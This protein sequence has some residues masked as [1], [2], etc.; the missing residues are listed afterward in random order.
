MFIESVLYAL[1]FFFDFGIIVICQPNLVVKLYRFFSPHEG[2]KEM[3]CSLLQEGILLFFV[4]GREGKI[5]I[6]ELEMNEGS[7]FL[8][9]VAKKSLLEMKRDF[10]EILR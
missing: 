2:R 4:L 9:G 5:R 6:I 1:A 3:L 10:H 8:I 7:I